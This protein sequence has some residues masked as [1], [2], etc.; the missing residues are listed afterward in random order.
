[1]NPL[2]VTATEKAVLLV[3]DDRLVL[4]VIMGCCMLSCAI[5]GAA[6]LISAAVKEHR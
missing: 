2:T 4:A 3:Q 1:M 5:W 6:Y